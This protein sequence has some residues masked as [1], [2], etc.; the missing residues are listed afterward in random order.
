MQISELS[1]NGRRSDSSDA[2]EQRS[3]TRA[4]AP[5]RRRKDFWCVCVK[6]AIHDILEERLEGR[7][8]GLICG[9]VGEDE[10]I[11]KYTTNQCR[12]RHCALSSETFDVD[13]VCRD[14]AAGNCCN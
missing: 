3:N 9:I 14:D 13:C 6:N 12:D 1:R 4:S 11:E 8:D 10:Q 2:V 5:T 7:A